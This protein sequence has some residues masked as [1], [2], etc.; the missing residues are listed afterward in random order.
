MP[1]RGAARIFL[2]D[3]PRATRARA[4][5]AIPLAHAMNAISL[6]ML[7]ATLAVAVAFD[8][9]AQRIPTTCVIAGLVLSLA[10]NLYLAARVEGSALLGIWP[11]LAGSTVGLVLLVPAYLLRMLGAGDVRLM[12]AAGAFL[13]PGAAVGAVFFTLI[14]GSVLMIGAALATR[15]LARLA[16]ELRA[17]F[18]AVVAGRAA[19]LDA[20]DAPA[21]ARLPYALA[22]ACGTALQLIA[23]ADPRWMIR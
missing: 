9:R 3:A 15:S 17:M 11:W 18:L 14:A 22:I 10:C 21:S 23:A 12:A 2:H 6:T 20:A 5:L 4:P 19:D 16:H 1:A 13:G 7:G 8:L